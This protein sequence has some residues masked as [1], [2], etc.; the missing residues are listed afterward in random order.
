MALTKEQ[1]SAIVD[2]VA[3]KLQEASS[4]YLTNFSGL[5]VEKSNELRKKFRES[6]V[7]YRVVKNTLLRR[8]MDRIGGYEEL[9]E[10]L[11]G[12]T[13]VAFSVEPAAPARVL[14]D[15]VKGSNKG[16]PELK[17][18]YIDGAIYDE[19]SLDALASLKSKAELI[20][21][22]MGLL[23]SPM[24]NVVGGLQSQ[25]STLVGAIKT[26]AEGKEEG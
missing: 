19:N 23:M 1:K 3:D 6:S 15:F 25:G 9:Y 4:I 16:L 12:P 17:G 18:A 21:D 14:K 13:A 8:A 26:I 20:G 11:D 5:S 7:E 2:E 22:I 10:K 24:S